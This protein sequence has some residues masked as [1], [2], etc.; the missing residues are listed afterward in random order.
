MIS[1]GV[2]SS[3][4]EALQNMTFLTILKRGSTTV[5]PFILPFIHRVEKIARQ[6]VSEK[7]ER[8]WSY[9]CSNHPDLKVAQDCLNDVHSHHFWSLTNQYP[10]LVKR[11]H[12]HVRLMCNFGFNG[13]VPWLRD[14]DSANV[15]YLQ[16]Y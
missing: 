10:D 15:F 13:G 3:I 16:A 1:I 2:V 7:Q 5:E 6:K 14:T 9:F 12:T 8:I 11:L 4:W